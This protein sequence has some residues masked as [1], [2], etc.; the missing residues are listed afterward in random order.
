MTR[1][2]ALI[3]QGLLWLMYRIRGHPYLFRM[4]LAFLDRLPW[5]RERLARRM[6]SIPTGRGRRELIL[7]PCSHASEAELVQYRLMRRIKQRET[8]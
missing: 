5:L 2:N 6:M 3:K 4:T 8:S 7:P 1:I